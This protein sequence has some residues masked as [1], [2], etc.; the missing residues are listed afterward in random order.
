[1]ESGGNDPI[2][3]TNNA[4]FS[5]GSV[6]WTN[7]GG[8]LGSIAEARAG[9]PAT[10]PLFGGSTMRHD[11]DVIT[12]RDPFTVAITLGADHLTQVMTSVTPALRAGAAAKNAG[13]AIANITDGYSG[14]SPD[15]G[16]II[17]GR[18]VPHRGATR[19]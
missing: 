9:L 4:W 6:W 13:V 17:E 19:P 18:A 1:M 12:A 5:D 16:A 8:S 11:N 14:A 3:F 10:T 15:I 2:D 7:T